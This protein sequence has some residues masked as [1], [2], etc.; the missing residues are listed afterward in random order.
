MI[1][2][3]YR[4]RAN[5]TS[6]TT[7]AVCSGSTARSDL[8][9]E[10]GWE[11]FDTKKP[12]F[13]EAF[14]RFC[15]LLYLFLL[16]TFRRERICTFEYFFGRCVLRQTTTYKPHALLDKPDWSIIPLNVRGLKDF[17]PCRGTH[18]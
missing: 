15:F 16:P 5:D 7:L 2:S 3:K 18:T 4:A 6:R 14:F 12:R 1:L 9:V 10:L 17:D 11:I 13:R 8:A